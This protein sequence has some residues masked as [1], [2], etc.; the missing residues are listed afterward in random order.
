MLHSCQFS[1]EAVVAQKRRKYVR[2]CPSL[3]G[4]GCEPTKVISVPS[5]EKPSVSTIRDLECARDSRIPHRVAVPIRDRSPTV[6]LFPA[7]QSAACAD[8]LVDGDRPRDNPDR[9]Q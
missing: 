3:T 5:V 7:L 8:I 1:C 6:Y 9:N 4:R 2:T